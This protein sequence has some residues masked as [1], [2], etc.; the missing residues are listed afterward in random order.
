MRVFT[1][2]LIIIIFSTGFVSAEEFILTGKQESVIDYRLEQKIEPFPGIER[3]SVSFVVLSDFHSPTYNQKISS[4]KFGFSLQPVEEEREVDERGNVIRVFHWNSPAKP[5]LCSVTLRAE[6]LVDFQPSF[7][8]GAAIP[9]T[10]PPEVKVFLQPTALVQSDNP[11]IIETARELTGG[12]ADVYGSVHA[13]LQYVVDRMRYT[14]T[15]DS[16]DAVYSFRTGKGNC[17]NYSHL[18]AAL[19][20]AVNIPARIVN[21]V[22]LKK[23]Y[24]IEAGEYEYSFDMAQGRHSWIEAYIPGA[25]WIP[26]DPQQTVYFVHNRYLRI[27]TGLDNGETGSDGLVRWSRSSGAPPGAPEVEEAY[28]ADFISDNIDIDRVGTLAGPRNLLLSPR[29]AEA[30]KPAAPKVTE[31]EKIPAAPSPEPEKPKPEPVDYTKLTYSLPLTMGNLDFPLNFNFLKAKYSGGGEAAGM[32]EIRRSFMVETAE[33]VTSQRQYA[34]CFVMQEPILLTKIGLAL[35][36][37]GGSGELWVEIF[38]DEGGMPASSAAESSRIPLPRIRIGEGYDWVDF[39]FS[40][41]GV[42][43]TPGRYWI[44]LHFSGSPIVNWFYTYGKPVG[45]VDGTRSRSVQG[46]RWDRVLTYEFNYRAEGLSSP[47]Y[48]SLHLKNSEIQDGG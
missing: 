3:L 11:L 8:P 29:L 20:R 7:V 18:A 44:A 17:Q 23:A 4:L 41:Q 43:L 27:E 33:Y 40:R 36:K 16:F 30:V 21:G 14:L 26:F 35:H 5:I 28:E 15:P 31:L 1:N 42:G 2:F 6:N 37:F 9:S 47:E 13:I 39:D 32:G 25:G 12:S 34:Q 24:T 19:L 10:Y 48:K 38:E 45:P 22:T 46:G